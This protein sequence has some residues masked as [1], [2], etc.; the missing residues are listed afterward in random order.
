MDP[1]TI[2]IGAALTGATAGT[3]L[4]RTVPTAYERIKDK[5]RR[6]FCKTVFITPSQNYPDFMNLLKFIAEFP[7]FKYSNCNFIR[8]G[9]QVYEVPTGNFTIPVKGHKFRFFIA[10][11]NSSQD[12]SHVTVSTWKRHPFSINM[13]RINIFDKFIRKFQSSA[14]VFNP[15]KIAT[16]IIANMSI[17]FRI[18]IGCGGRSNQQKKYQK[19][20][21]RT[22]VP[23][24]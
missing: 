11:N 22:D 1:A 20:E 15:K 10:T 23:L 2:A 7:Q 18:A 6:F 9:N 16:K 5:L 4:N 17:P 14:D 8:D 21:N 3:V 24:N 13:E 19:L 12:I